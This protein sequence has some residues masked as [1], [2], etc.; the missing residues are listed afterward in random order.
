MKNINKN[1][2]TLNSIE[3]NKVEIEI[4]YK[5]INK[6]ERNIQDN[7]EYISVYVCFDN[8]LSLETMLFCVQSVEIALCDEIKVDLSEDEEKAILNFAKEILINNK[9]RA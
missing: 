8:D 1:L 3:G 5:G 9:A 7:D 4:N 6:L 2:L